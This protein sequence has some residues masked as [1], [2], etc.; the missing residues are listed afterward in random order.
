MAARIHPAFRGLVENL[1]YG[2]ST[3]IRG[4]DIEICDCATGDIEVHLEESDC[5]RF[6]LKIP[7]CGSVLKWC[8]IFDAEHPKLPPD[9]ILDP[10]D[11]TFCPVLSDLKSLTDW[12]PNDEN[13]LRLV[14][15][16]LLE[17]FSKH[18]LHIAQQIDHIKF[19]TEFLQE[20]THYCRFD[21]HVK[22]REGSEVY[23]LVPVIVI[24]CLA[25]S[26]CVHMSGQFE[27]KVIH[28]AACCFYI[29]SCILNFCKEDF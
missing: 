15:Y 2:S 3:F 9:I 23:Q 27:S 12:D 10:S 26:T 11:S 25:I 5:D 24:H 18:Q 8:V 4:G 19:N 1:L 16:Q 7:Y 6:S 21:V 22:K 17:L 29:S 14:V 13:S 28:S 20:S